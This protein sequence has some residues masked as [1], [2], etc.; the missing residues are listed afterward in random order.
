MASKT[1]VSKQT[2]APKRKK[3]TFVMVDVN[4]GE[5]NLQESTLK[6]QKTD[7]TVETQSPYLLE[8]MFRK[9][10]RNDSDFNFLLMSGGNNRNLLMPSN[11]RERKEFMEDYLKCVRRGRRMTGKEQMSGK[12]ANKRIKLMLDI[13]FEFDEP[14]PDL[15]ILFE[16]IKGVVSSKYCHGAAI[17]NY[18][19]CSLT[20]H[21]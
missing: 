14:T 2:L 8:K 20:A 15:D 11:E 7:S 16:T 19:G 1:T 10:Y 9:K 18:Y 13:D 3:D 5:A 17:V 4:D 21:S 6:E 12:H